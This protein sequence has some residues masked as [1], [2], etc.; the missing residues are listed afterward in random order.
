M[1]CSELQET[2]GNEHGIHIYVYY[3][4]NHAYVITTAKINLQMF[5]TDFLSSASPESFPDSS[6][7]SLH[8][9]TGTSSSLLLRC[10]PR[11]VAGWHL[12][13]LSPLGPTDH[14]GFPHLSPQSVDL[15]PM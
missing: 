9:A 6:P 12:N 3:E 5:L 7:K 15:K 13:P 14:H 4:C 8:E 2:I 10:L 11:E 1:M